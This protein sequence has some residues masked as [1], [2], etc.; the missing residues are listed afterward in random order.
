MK[1]ILSMPG[2]RRLAALLAA[3]TAFAAF[4]DYTFFVELPS[5]YATYGEYAAGVTAAASS[6]REDAM[7]GEL[8]T[9]T[10]SYPV[11]LM[12]ALEARY[13]TWHESAGIGLWS[14]KGGF[15][16]ILK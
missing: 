16:V 1:R 2:G 8:A 10:L 12:V 11:E 5:G 6:S 14:T 3:A 7:D 9:G 15:M 4:A 13:R